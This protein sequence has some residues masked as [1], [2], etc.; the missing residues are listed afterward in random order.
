MNRAE[1]IRIAIAD[2]LSPTRLV[3]EDDSARHAG[4]A[5]AQ[6]GGETH[7]NL[8]I[9]ADAFTGQ[10]RVAR[11]RAVHEILAREFESGLHALSIRALSPAEARNETN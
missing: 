3:V 10:S 4:H 8:L 7:F 11:Q 6:P 1:R 5:G 2:S 9:V